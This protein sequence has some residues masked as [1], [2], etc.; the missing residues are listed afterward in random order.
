MPARGAGAAARTVWGTCMRRAATH[1]TGEGHTHWHRVWKGP[2]KRCEATAQSA[3]G[4]LFSSV[5]AVRARVRPRG[6]PTSYERQ[7]ETHALHSGQ[8]GIAAHS[9]APS[10][11]KSYISAHVLY[12]QHAYE[13]SFALADAPPP[14]ALFALLCAGDGGIALA[15]VLGGSFAGDDGISWEETISSTPFSSNAALSASSTYSLFPS[16]LVAS[17]RPHFCFQSP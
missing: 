15:L 7:R 1:A 13:F 14:S 4:R 11:D 17:T 10:C 16:L 12:E 2:G 9:I 5:R 6:R 3:L 8:P